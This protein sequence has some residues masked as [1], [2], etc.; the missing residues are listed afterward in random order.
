MNADVKEKW[1]KALRSG[2]YHQGFTQLRVENS[3]C[4]L[5]VLCDLYGKEHHVAWDR[6]TGFLFEKYY[7][8]EK[9]KKW[10]GLQN[11]LPNSNYP[12][13]VTFRPGE[14]LPAIPLACLNDGQFPDSGIGIERRQ[15]TFPEIADIIERHL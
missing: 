3:Y 13:N 11:E 10:A 6:V 4:C 2:E 7:L 8:P 14:S 15:Y 1:V 5:G 12:G 9:V